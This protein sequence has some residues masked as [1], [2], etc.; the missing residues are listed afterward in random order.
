MPHLCHLEVRH[1]LLLVQWETR[2]CNFH[3]N[4]GST[5]GGFRGFKGTMAPKLNGKSRPLGRG[6][7]ELTPH[8]L[9]KR[10]SGFYT[11]L[12]RPTS[13]A[14]PSFC[15]APN[16]SVWIRLWVRPPPLWIETYV[17]WS[18]RGVLCHYLVD[19]AS[20]HLTL[21]RHS[22]WGWGNICH[23][24]MRTTVYSIVTALYKRCVKLFSRIKI[25]FLWSTCNDVGLAPEE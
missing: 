6:E 22:H 25:R 20:R 4:S 19:F 18:D 3:L 8:F 21:D 14:V 15:L 1:S 24:L 13:F 11:I 9:G 10:S 16:F 12:H 17:E 7:A 2:R 5:N 23:N